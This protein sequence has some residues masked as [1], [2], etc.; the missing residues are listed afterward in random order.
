MEV[1]VETF[2]MVTVA[3]LS[4]V[5]P[6]VTVPTI[7]D[8]VSCANRV[9]VIVEHRRELSKTINNRFISVSLRKDVHLGAIWKL[10]RGIILH[11]SV[12]IM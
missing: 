9:G 3:P 8:V 10:S 7:C 1:P 2:V 5:L 6:S 11:I 12:I 4:G